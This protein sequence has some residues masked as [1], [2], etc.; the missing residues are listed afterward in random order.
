M[1]EAFSYSFLKIEFKDIYDDLIKIESSKDIEEKNKNIE[2]LIEDIICKIYTKSNILYNDKLS[3]IEKLNDLESL[4]LIPKD[5][6]N[7]IIFFVEEILD[8]YIQENNFMSSDVFNERKKKELFHILVWFVVTYGEENYFLFI[9]NLN[10]EEQDI[11]NKYMYK[12]SITNYTSENI[13][14]LSEEEKK[15][16]GKLLVEQGENYYF[17]KGVKSSN[18]E[19]LKYFR[20]AVKYGDTQAQAYL[21]LFYDKG[22]V[23]KRN[24]E[25]AYKWYYKAAMSGNSFA[26][27]SLAMMYLSGSGVDK[28]REKAV[29]WFQKSAENEY[30]PAFFQLGRSYYYG[31]GVEKNLEQSF[32]WYKRAAEDNL[33]AAQYILSMMYKGGEGCEENLVKA[34]YWI[35]KAADNDYEDAYYIVGKSYL[36]G[37]VYN[38]NLERAYY[39]LN[40]GVLSEDPNCMEALALMYKEGL[41][42]KKDEVKALELLN[43]AIDLGDDSLYY[44]VAKIYEEQGATKLAIQTYEEGH[45]VDQIKCTQRLGIIY[46]NGEGVSRDIDKAIKYM[47]IAARQK[48][49]HAMYMLAIAY[50][51]INKFG[52]KTN[53][54]VKELLLESFK[55]GSP[56]AAEYLAYININEATEGKEFNKKDLIK[57]INYGISNN[58]SDCKFQYGYIYENGIAVDKDY[59]KAYYW[60]ISAAEDKCIKAMLKLGEWYKIGKYLERNID[61]SIKWYEKAADLKDSEAIEKL[62]EIYE[63]GIGDRR[64]EV[65]AVY[66]VFK[67]A[68]M[69]GIK[70][71]KKLAYYCYKGIGVEENIKKGEELIEEI[72]EIDNGTS[73][74]LICRLAKEGLINMTKDEIIKNYTEGIELGNLECYGELSEYLYKEN[75]YNTKE[76]KEIFDIAMEGNKLGII[77]CAYICY[78]EQLKGKVDEPI[79]TVEE[80]LIIK[81]LKKLVYKGLYNIL[82]DLKHWYQIRNSKDKSGYYNILDL[83][84]YFNVKGN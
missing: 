11:F 77:K 21:G 59:E 12:R 83:I 60:Y 65:K 43:N 49:P 84:D 41:F 29:L 68:D 80:I 64:N 4:G 3:Y 30:S 71:K 58:I 67:L 50:L 47:E 26:Q 35:E 13:E 7:I 76:Y 31:V 40:K 55:L 78:M 5:I 2:R 70:A 36:E 24:Y 46:Y 62:I 28:N 61:L 54:K 72:K 25:I 66:Y 9:D 38:Q 22:I 8:T 33:P 34:Y 32:K 79:V 23:V 27:Y 17:G 82:N 63:Q 69:D 56:Y 18:S 1:Q 42:V 74:E 73:K 20:K 19:A 48:A 39:Y 75:L 44:K 52:E 6:V 53:D 51:R 15:E 57:Y 45:K 81:N 16:K 14:S 37:V 10:K